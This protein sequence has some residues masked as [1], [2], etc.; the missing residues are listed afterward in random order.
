M[1]CQC[2]AL[3]I[4]QSAN[5]LECTQHHCSC[6]NL[7]FSDQEECLLSQILCIS[8]VQN[9]FPLALPRAPELNFLCSIY[10]VILDSLRSPTNGL[11]D[12]LSLLQHHPVTLNYSPSSIPC[13]VSGYFTTEVRPTL[14]FESMLICHV[15]LQQI[16][17]IRICL[18]I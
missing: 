15:L 13:E 10:S 18:L 12:M 7:P 16:L 14:L 5:S 2:L 1:V 3:W 6:T 11:L 4:H 8:S 17:L 9:P